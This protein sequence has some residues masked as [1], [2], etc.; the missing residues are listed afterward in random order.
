MTWF[1]VD[2]KLHDHRKARAAGKSAMGV[3]VLAGS[4]AADHLTDGF[5]PASIL[6][7]WGTRAD[8]AKL[9][10]VGLWR[11][12]EQEGEKGWRFHDWA[13]LQPTRAQKTAERE[14]RAAAGRVG[15]KASGRSRREAK[16]KQPASGIVEPP[17]RPVPTTAAAAADDAA[18]AAVLD[19][20]LAVLRSKL[21]AHTPLRGLRFDTL[22]A[23]QSAQLVALVAVHG[24]DPLVRVAIDTCRNPAPTHASAFLGTWAALPAPGQ[25]LQVVKQSL[26]EIHQTKKSPSGVCSNCASEQIASNR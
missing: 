4:W 2:D 23:E 13:E 26:C 19:P 15:G 5:V 17:S 3:W 6:A 11:P 21:Q 22:T 16:S 8:A 7:R 10:T 20:I 1:K 12:D 9:V 25:R 24:D 14:A 18:A